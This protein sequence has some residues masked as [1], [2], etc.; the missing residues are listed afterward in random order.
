MKVT[1]ELKRLFIIEGICGIA[2]IIEYF[3][4]IQQ[5]EKPFSLVFFYPILCCCLVL[6][7]G[8]AFWFTCL[9]H[10][11]TKANPSK[12]IKA[13]YR[14]FRAFDLLCILF[15]PI[16][17]FYCVRNTTRLY[18]GLAIYVFAIL[19]YINYFYIRLSYPIKEF[20]FHVI[21]WDFGKSRIARMLK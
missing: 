6:L 2:F 17:L 20:F 18:I 21:K 15:Y 16:I 12:K 5:L 7:Q 4:L 13:I 10:I 1:H 8:S 9:K 14:F 11:K 3:A 19:E